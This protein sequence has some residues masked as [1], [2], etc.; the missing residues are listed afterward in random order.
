MRYFKI[1]KNFLLKGPWLGSLTPNLN[2]SSHIRSFEQRL[3]NDKQ[4]LYDFRYLKSA[5]LQ[6]DKIHDFNAKSLDIGS[7]YLGK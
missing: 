1:I 3:Y 6:N 2:K 5:Y 7:E 4:K